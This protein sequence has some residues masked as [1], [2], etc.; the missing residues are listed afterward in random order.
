MTALAR[1]V[2]SSQFEWKRPVEMGRL[3]VC[4]SMRTSTGRFFSSGRSTLSIREVVS[5]TR[6]SPLSKKTPSGR[7]STSSLRSLMTCRPWSATFLFS[8]IWASVFLSSSMTDS[9]PCSACPADSSGVL[10]PDMRLWPL[11]GKTSMPTAFEKASVN[12]P[13]FFE[14]T[15]DTAN[16]TTKNAKRS[17]MKSA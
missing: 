10:P 3:S 11:I 1:A 4:P 17:V 7:R 14:S 12:R 15:W 13:T 16:M 5:L 6:A 2:E 9:M 8:D